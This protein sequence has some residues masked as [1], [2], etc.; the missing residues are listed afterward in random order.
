MLV[1]VLL[2]QINKALPYVT[3]SN[4]FDIPFPSLMPYAVYRRDGLGRGEAGG[5]DSPITLFF[6][7]TVSVAQ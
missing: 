7:A 5:S 4:K 1:L 3:L 6:V 2:W